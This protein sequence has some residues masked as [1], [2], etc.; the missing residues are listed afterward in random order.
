[1]SLGN[2]EAIATGRYLLQQHRQNLAQSLRLLE[3]GGFVTMPGCYLVNDPE[4]PDTIIGVVIGMAQGS[5]IIPI[6]KPVIGVSASSSDDSP[7]VKLSGRAHK[8]LIKRGINLKETFVS[9]ANSLNEHYGT[10]IAEAGGHPMAA[11]AFI[12]KEHIDEFLSQISTLLDKILK[13][14][15]T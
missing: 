7:L 10:L 5:H 8:N 6:D 13:S 4:I 1:V 9:V 3:N 2:Q 11:G 14:E 15:K 12:Q